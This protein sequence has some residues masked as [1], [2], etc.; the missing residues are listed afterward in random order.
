MKRMKS[1]LA[2]YNNQKNLIEI[3]T[4]LNEHNDFN[5]ELP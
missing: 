1:G 2:N 3:L 4:V 5:D